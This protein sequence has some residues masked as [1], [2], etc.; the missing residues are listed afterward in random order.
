MADRRGA[1]RPQD[2]R[3]FCA[4]MRVVIGEL[5]LVLLDAAVELVGER[6]DGGVHVLLDGVGVHGAAVQQHG[7]FGFVAQLL[8]GQDAMNVYDVVRV[9]DDAVQLFLDIALHRRGDIDVVTGDVQLHGSLL[10]Q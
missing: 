10:R 3:G 9:P 6:V 2:G 5:F 1:E 8:D 7:G 4:S